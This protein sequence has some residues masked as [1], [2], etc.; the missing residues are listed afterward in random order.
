MDGI[1]L[2]IELEEGCRL[3]EA[4]RLLAQP[5]GRRGR[6]RPIAALSCVTRSRLLMAWLTCAMPEFCSRVV[7]AMSA[8]LWVTPF[9]L[10]STCAIVEPALPASLAPV[11]M[12]PTE[13]PINC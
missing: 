13:A 2:R 11:S 3:L 7:W 12:R 9:T 4:G 10:W 5:F 8:M 1:A 6:M